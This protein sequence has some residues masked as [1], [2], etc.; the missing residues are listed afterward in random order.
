M[1]TRCELAGMKPIN[2]EK[3]MDHS[4]GISNSYSPVD[5]HKLKDALEYISELAK[6][7]YQNRLGLLA[8]NILFGLIVLC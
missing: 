7:G 3:L 4:I 6:V 5:I 1:K 2:I 8:H